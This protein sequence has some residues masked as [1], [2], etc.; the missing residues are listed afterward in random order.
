MPVTGIQVSLDIHGSLDAAPIALCIFRI[1]Q[2]TLRNV[3][4]HSGV[5]TAAV[6]VERTAGWLRLSISD[7]GKGMDTAGVGTGAGLGLVSIKERARLVHGTLEI[8][9]GPNQGTTIVVRIPDAT[10]FL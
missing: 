5:K 3:A 6:E 9:S 2:E 4:K 1:T 10:L 7:A 8:Q